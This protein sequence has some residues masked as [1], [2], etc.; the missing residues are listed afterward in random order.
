MAII[1]DSF[2]PLNLNYATAF[3]KVQIRSDIASQAIPDTVHLSCA[4]TGKNHFELV[5]SSLNHVFSMWKDSTPWPLL[6]FLI[7][8]PDG[9]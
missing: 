2:S 5:K 6:E 4:T 7:F 1:T 3:V 9:L 8:P